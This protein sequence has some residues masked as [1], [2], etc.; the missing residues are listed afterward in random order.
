[1]Q[2]DQD[3]WAGVQQCF[4]ELV[5]CWL[6]SHPLQEAA[7]RLERDETYVALAFARF[8]QAII[9][10]QVE[11]SQ[12]QHTMLYLRMSLNSA[13]LDMLRASSR[14]RKPCDVDNT[15]E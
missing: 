5:R 8:Y 2:S 7:R 1:M 3:A 4:G 14:S 10:Q 6:R 13:I 12:L 11:L 15:L 9:Q